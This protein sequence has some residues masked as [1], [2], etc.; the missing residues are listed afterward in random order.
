M[1]RDLA[2]RVA[3]RFIEASAPIEVKEV[4]GRIEVSGPY[5][6]IQNLVPYLRGKLE[7]RGRDHTWWVPK[8]KMTPLK[9]KNLQKKVNEINGVSGPEPKKVE[10]SAEAKEARIE[11]AKKLF[12]RAISM[13]VPGL[14]FG[15]IP[16]NAVQLTGVLTDLRVSINKAGGDYGPEFSKFYPHLIKPVEFEKLLDEVEDQGRLVAKAIADL[17]S[18]IPRKFPNLKIDVGTN[19]GSYL[20]VVSGK[21]YDF[22]DEIKKLV[23]V[24]FNG[25]GSFWYA[26]IQKVKEG[27]VKELIGYLEGEERARAEK[28]KAEKA[29]P[30]EERKRTNQRG[31]HCHDCGGW[32]EPG[33][34]YLFNWYDSEPGDFVWK[35]KHK[36]P[37]DCAKVRA[38]KKIRNEAARTKGEAR[39]NLMLMCMRSEYYVDGTG[40]RP[41]G[42]E[43][44]IDKNSLGYGGGTWVVVEPGGNYFWYVKNN[45]ADGDDWSRNNVSTGG[46]G[47]IG[48][49]LPMT[50]EARVLIDVAKDG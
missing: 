15:F 42:E 14:S 6:K 8:A 3:S 18:I 31:E 1:S 32:V 48:Y 39:K 19:N 21:T 26:P 7:Y 40:H 35:V 10:E 47:A 12:H 49:R 29:P 36:D 5:D 45:G 9:I 13:R 16:V 2:Q 30:A 46:A 11:E 38:E 34:G 24:T 20:F 50:D 17:S 22:K 33:E 37:E 28:W 23:P 25:Q 4:E 41:S 44:Y 43:I 27:Q